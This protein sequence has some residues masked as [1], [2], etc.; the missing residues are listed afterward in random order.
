MALYNVKK[1]KMKSFTYHKHETKKQNKKNEKS[2][3]NHYIT[4]LKIIKFT[5]AMTHSLK[6]A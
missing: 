6:I 2:I 4:G 3:Y 1:G 5:K